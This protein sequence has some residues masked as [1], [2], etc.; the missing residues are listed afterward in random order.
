MAK[1]NKSR[2]PQKDNGIQAIFQEA[3][4]VT[5]PKS[6]SMVKNIGNSGVPK[7]TA[8]IGPGPSSLTVHMQPSSIILC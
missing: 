7:V 2:H 6:S 1:E 3:D 8:L 4:R 5:D